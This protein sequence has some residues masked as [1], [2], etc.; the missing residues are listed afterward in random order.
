MSGAR[1]NQLWVLLYQVPVMLGRDSRSFVPGFMKQYHSVYT[2][3]GNGDV[4]R[5]GPR[6]T[7]CPKVKY[8]LAI[9]NKRITFNFNVYASTYSFCLLNSF[10]SYLLGDSKLHYLLRLYDIIIQIYY[11]LQFIMLVVGSGGT[12]RSK[13]TI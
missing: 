6:W 8:F 9:S 4:V 12:F 10:A 13:S 7:V 2:E 3:D 5:D 11:Y 1:S